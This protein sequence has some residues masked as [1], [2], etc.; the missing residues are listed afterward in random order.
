MT[1]NIDQ[2]FL[3]TKLQG[4][5]LIEDGNSFSVGDH[6]RIT[7]AVY[8]Q[9]DQRKCSYIIIK[10]KVT[11]SDGSV[12]YLVNSYKPI[13]KDWAV[14]PDNPYKKYRF[15]KR[16]EIPFT[17]KCS[18]CNVSVKNPYRTCYNCRG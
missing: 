10:D 13:Y 4:Y 14:S 16:E 7:Q 1:M 12:T 6:L 11:Q 9:P 5:Q 3:E 15:Y 18:R 17:G 2:E 8:K